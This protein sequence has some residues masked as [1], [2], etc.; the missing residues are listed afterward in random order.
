MMEELYDAL[1]AANVPDDKARAAAREVAK[2]STELLDIRGILKL[3][4]WMLGTQI[5]MTM[6]ILFKVFS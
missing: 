4:S 3:H 5:S 6:A 1:R 2:H